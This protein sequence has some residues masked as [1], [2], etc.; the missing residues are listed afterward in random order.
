[1][2]AVGL[3][4]WLS[5]VPELKSRIL[6]TVITVNALIFYAVTNVISWALDPSYPRSWEGLVQALTTGL[7]GYPPT[8]VFFRNALVSDFLFVGLIFV[9][10]NWRPVRMHQTARATR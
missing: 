4:R 1:M 8:W 9:V 2:I 3:G 6:V 5:E 10:D 7:P